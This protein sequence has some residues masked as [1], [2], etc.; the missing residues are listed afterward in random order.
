M[1]LT[2]LILAVLTTLFLQ[3][4]LTWAQSFADREYYLIDSL[5]LDELTETDHLLADSC[6]KLYHKAERDMDK[7]NALDDI[8]ENMMHESWTKYQQVQYELIKKSLAKIPA[9]EGEERRLLLVSLAAALNNIGYIHKL[10]GHISEALEYYLKSLQIT[11][12]LKDKEGTATALNNIG[13]IYSRQGDIKTSLSYYHNS[14]KIYK[15]IDDISGIATTLGNIGLTHKDRGDLET[16]LDYYHQA[17]TKYEELRDSPDQNS[18]RAGKQGI[19]ISW[20]NIGRICNQQGDA[21]KGLNC[22][23]KS[24]KIYEELG[25]KK[26][27]ASSLNNVA[28]IYYD[29]GETAKAIDWYHESLTIRKEIGDK[30]GVAN[31]MYNIG[32]IHLDEGKFRLAKECATKMMDLSK[33]MGNPNLIRHAAS[34]LSNVAKNEGNYELALEMYELHIQ[35]SDSIKNEETQKSVIRQQTKYEFEKAQLIKDQQL[36]EASRKLQEEISRRDNLQ[37]SIIF[38]T[39]LL[40]FASVLGLGFVKVSPTIAEG[41]IF[42]AFLIL[43]EFILVLSDPYIDSFTG[44]APVYKLLANAILAGLIFPAHGFFE[45]LLKKRIIKIKEPS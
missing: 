16:G 5:V 14:L 26:G 2:K 7:I 17:L 27:V 44:G 4:K 9:P 10:D 20:N 35:M 34:M 15:E 23:L 21:E 39:L 29:L 8:C 25:H 45:G 24:L 37:Y 40:V 36:Q 1:K 43:F 19:A 3:T 33:K 31:S 11:E 18:T 28:H 30:R 32:S 38:L 41:L 13:A 42:F 6:L 22:Y 12:E